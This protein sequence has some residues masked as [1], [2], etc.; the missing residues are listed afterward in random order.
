[1]KSRKT[2]VEEINV[3]M[4]DFEGSHQGKVGFPIHFCWSIKIP[5]PPLSYSVHL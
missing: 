2:N 5:L 3:T 1:M 4:N